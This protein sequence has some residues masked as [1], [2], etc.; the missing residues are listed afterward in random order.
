MLDKLLKKVFGDKN[1]R[2]YKKLE[3]LLERIKEKSSVIEEKTDEE[4]RSRVN[5]IKEEI[6][7]YLSSSVQELEEL[8]EKY[9][10]EHEEGEKDRLEN[11]IDREA[12]ELKEMRQEI[13]D[14]FLPE[15][16]AIVRDTCRRL[17]GTEYEIRGHKETWFMVP[18]DVQ[19]IGGI[20]LH[21]GMITEMATG[22]GKTLVAT[23]PMFLNALTGLGVH[24]ITVNDY[25]ARRD[26]EWMGPIFAFHNLTVGV[27]TTGMDFRDR[28]E[29]YD[30]DITYGTNSEFGFDYLRD[31]MATHSEQLVQGYLYYAIIDEVD[32]VLIDEARTPL[33]ISGPVAESK[34]FYAELKPQIAKLVSVQRNLVNRY[35]SEIRQSL[36]GENPDWEDVGKKML[37]VKRAAPKNKAFRKLM[38][39][40]T[41][42]KLVSDMEGVYLRDK[43]M[44]LLDEDLF[45]VIDE[46]TNSADLCEKGRDELSRSDPYLF[47]LE[48][49]D[50]LLNQ[51]EEREDLSLEQK[52]QEKEKITARFL[53][54]NERLHNIA[55]L[56]KS[57][58]LFE[59][60]VDYVVMNNQVIIVDEF[61]GRMMPGRRFSDGLH[62]ALEAKEG[63]RIEGATQ[64]LA[65]ITLQNYFRM[66]D[67]IAGMTGTAVTEE[68]EFMEIYKLPVMVVPTNLPITRIDYDDMIYLTK[69]QKY[70]AIMNEI[71]YWHERK[72]PVLVGTVSV[73]VSE[74]LSRLLNRRGIAHNVLNAKNHERE[75]D[76]I[77]F[78]GDPGSVT[79]ATNMA[80][81]GTDIK[82][83]KGVITLPQE[84]YREMHSHVT[85]ENPYGI[86]EDGLHVIGT[87]RHESRRIDRQLRGRSGRQGDP[88]TS[89]FYLSLED[90]LMR[91]FGSDR[92]APMMSRLGLK[93][94]DAITHPWMTNA[95]EKAQ[96]RVEA[97]NFEIRKQLLKYDEVM[98]QQREV[99]YKYRRSVLKGYDLKFEIMEMVKESI[100]RLVDSFI[101]EEEYQE[102]WNIDKIA[103]WLKLNLGFNVEEDELLSD[104]LTLDILQANVED[105]VF[106]AYEKREE[107]IGEEELRKVERLSLLQ[108]VD[109]HWRDHLHEMDLLKEGVGL[110]AYANKDPLIEYKKESF[111]LFQS[112]IA[113]IQDSVT[114]RVFTVR[115]ITSREQLAD[116]LKAAR[117]THSDISAFHYQS[118][119]VTPQ[120]DEYS[121]ASSKPH[122]VEQRRV[123]VKIGRNDPCPCGS[124]KKY[125]KCC[126]SVENA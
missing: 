125:K 89:R 33:I 38:K 107:D 26:S 54:K 5:E 91:L 114:K 48:Q 85:S 101:G 29:A 7:E 79:I 62:Q 32:S 41:L 27:I 104:Y 2:D 12:S 28:K 120:A 70:E 121:S 88:G 94:T 36:E 119:E 86:P 74:T 103:Q 110:R 39:D 99:I 56:L 47:V 61:T 8:R 115:F 24:L 109:T 25:L 123:D 90:D 96:K 6:R 3:P 17:I 112:L 31:N 108:V 1:L 50:D 45:Y 46:K 87:E 68:A 76:I 30:C 81:R 51:L 106:K 63:V 64:T 9:Q 97:H 71:V 82:L 66:Y 124:G 15:V 59:K 49:L 67:K 57:Y 126:G 73:E 113:N 118:A 117:T 58:S 4:L 60:D 100:G 65:T 95:V 13:L 20:A 11:E 53:D 44:H 80:G 37:L 102:N 98:N 55:Q 83:G 116:L 69:K 84:K 23:L 92:I 14:R 21:Q 75:A 18:F 72:K 35:M 93:E 10:T 111:V 19:L 16:F 42:K 78:A 40:S 43:K 34:N 77:M 105:V 52:I 122:K 22:E